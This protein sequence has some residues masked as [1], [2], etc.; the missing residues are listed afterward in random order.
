MLNTIFYAEQVF[1]DEPDAWKAMV[2]RGMTKDYSW[3]ASAKIY[4]ELYDSL[5]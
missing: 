5:L 1:Y 2:E 4:E 3:T